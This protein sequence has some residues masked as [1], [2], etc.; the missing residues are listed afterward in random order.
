MG[1]RSGAC[2]VLVTRPE[3]EK[4]LEYSETSDNQELDIRKYIFLKEYF[5][6]VQT[7]NGR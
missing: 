2:R 4:P 7:L 3:G 1:E 6:S 5:S